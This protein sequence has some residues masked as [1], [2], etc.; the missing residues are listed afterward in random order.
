[1]DY[2]GTIICGADPLRLAMAES[3]VC[4]FPR[5]RDG[6]P[7]RIG[8][9][10]TGILPGWSEGNQRAAFV[11]AWQAWEEVCGLQAIWFDSSSKAL[12]YHADGKLEGI[13]AI[14]TVRLD[15]ASGVLADSYLPCGTVRIRQRY[16]TSEAWINAERPPS[17]RIDLVRV[18]AHEIG[19]A[20][21]LPHIANGNLL[22][23]MYS[24]AIRKPQSGD[25]AEAVRRYGPRRAPAPPP[26]NPV[27]PAGGGGSV[28]RNEILNTIKGVLKAAAFAAK[29][30]PTQ[31]DDQI[32][33]FIQSLVDFL[34]GLPAGTTQEQAK[35][36]LV[37]H[38]SA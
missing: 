12:G 18:A 5:N 15:G 19:H 24:T 10:Y 34:S 36:A 20:I 25:I 14:N 13:V 26:V 22:Q 27:P 1:M 32:I 16:D 7:V 33:G 4:A 9:Y 3:Q 37:Q 8:W 28:D 23:P 31:T 2:D 6:G 30:T 38:L 21:G 29:L 11:E 17:N 35:A